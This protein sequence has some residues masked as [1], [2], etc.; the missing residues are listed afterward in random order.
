MRRLA[1]SSDGQKMK[2]DEQ[3]CN[4]RDETDDDGACAASVWRKKSYVHFDIGET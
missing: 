4:M 1:A 3:N 2:K